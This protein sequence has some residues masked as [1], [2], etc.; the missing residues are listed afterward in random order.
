MRA[1]P[2][3][4]PPI[5]ERIAEKENFVNF[6]INF[7]SGSNVGDNFSGDLVSAIISGR[8]KQKDDKE[9]DAELSLLCKLA[10]ANAQRRK[11]LECDVFFERESYFYNTV[12]PTF[13]RF[14]QERGLS[15]EDQFK[16]FPKCYEAVY[17]PENGICVII[18]EDLRTK[19]FAMWPKQKPAPASYCR[20]FVREMAKFHA[21]SFAMKDQQPERFEEFKKLNDLTN[22]YVKVP[23]KVEFFWNSCKRVIGALENENHK[24]IVR[25]IQNNI[26]A[27]VASCLGRE[28][29]NRFGV[30]SHGDCWNNN[31]LYRPNEKVS[32]TAMKF[33][34]RSVLFSVYNNRALSTKFPSLIGR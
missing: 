9:V 11:E 13:T 1:L 24:D 22:V 33:S 31:F 3:Y 21:I 8:R 4:L 17:D 12:A 27:Y 23:N 26:P 6:T 14:Q 28:A 7:G 19:G 15:E 16:A 18:M 25:D 5:L 2:E 30:I 20:L 32:A 29:A 34:I 10:P